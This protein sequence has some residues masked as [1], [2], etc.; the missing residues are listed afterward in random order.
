MK[1]LGPEFGTNNI[2]FFGQS[3]ISSGFGPQKCPSEHFS[4][5]SL[6]KTLLIRPWRGGGGG[7]AKHPTPMSDAS[8]HVLKQADRPFNFQN[9]GLFLRTPLINPSD[10]SD[11]IWRRSRKSRKKSKDFEKCK[12]I[13]IFRAFF[14]AFW[15]ISE[16]G[17]GDSSSRKNFRAMS[18]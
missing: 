10:I 6:A 7:R 12:K 9:F 16:G 2:T 1:P 14:F 18:L 13:R 4:C 15:W 11:F 3:N 17:R 8:K 5:F